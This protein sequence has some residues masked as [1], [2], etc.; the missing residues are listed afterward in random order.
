MNKGK[1][2]FRFSSVILTL[3]LSLNLFSYYNDASA[4]TKKPRKKKQVEESVP[5]PRMSPW[6]LRHRYTCS[7]E[8]M[9]IDFD[10][11]NGDWR[12]FSTSPDSYVENTVIEG[13]GP[14][15]YLESGEV[16]EAYQ[17]GNAVTERESIDS[18]F[19]NGKNFTATFP[20]K[21]GVLIKQRVTTFNNYS[22]VVFTTSITNNGQSPIYVRKI[23]VLGFPKAAGNLHRNV[24]KITLLPVENIAGFWRYAEKGNSQVL[25]IASIDGMKHILFAVVSIGKGKSRIV[26]TDE[27][28]ASEGNIECEYNPPVLLKPG[29]VIESEP[30]VVSF[31]NYYGKLLSNVCWG[32]SGI[33][34]AVS[35]NSFPGKARRWIQP[36]SE[37]STQLSLQRIAEFSKSVGI[38]DILVPEGWENPPGSCKGDSKKYGSN[39]K[40]VVN[41]LKGGK[42]L[43]VGLV[44]NPW[45]VPVGSEH[46][47]DTNE[48]YAIANYTS[49]EGIKVAER[50]WSKIK[51]W[52]INFILCK[53]NVPEKVLRELNSTNEEAAIIGIRELSRFFE[54]VA[55]YPV[56]SDNVISSKDT[57]LKYVGFVSYAYESGS[58]IAPS[59]VD[60]GLL[61][62]ADE[63]TEFALNGREHVWAWVGDFSRSDIKEKLSIFRNSNDCVITP[64]CKVGN[65]IPV[66]RIRR[67]DDIEGIEAPQLLCIYSSISKVEEPF[68]INSV[69]L[70]DKILWDLMGSNV[71]EK[72]SDIKFE[73]VPYVLLG[74]VKKS[75]TPCVVGIKGRKFGGI[76][77]V[78]KIKWT[79]DEKRLTVGL[80]SNF[81]GS[82]ELVVY[83]P[84]QMKLQKVLID[85]R[86]YKNF[87]ISTNFVRISLKSSQ[88]TVDLLFD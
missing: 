85:G 71:I 78:K 50:R 81:N 82:E 6:A 25:E 57:L 64:I 51:D 53:A 79:G 84:S 12:I 33:S 60:N 86:Q 19:G 54:K 55:V 49:P 10:E 26:F 75:Q 32:V 36:L 17:I 72:V 58:G 44:L 3:L 29:E 16:I 56:F 45:V 43:N 73:N 4:A 8:D 61:L 87:V 2:F 30:V 18:V 21:D 38:D 66:W 27:S 76:G 42:N 39:M 46:S 23:R 37:K 34:Q 67:I 74:I 68:I 48:G 69:E 70:S 7:W 88:E 52:G 9:G 63:I 40:S 11:F 24:G 22:F 77:E 83:I 65:E 62:D 35:K 41:A 80:N 47:I 14:I 31:G 20:V 15:I 13:Y 59:M 1:L 28:S 5:T